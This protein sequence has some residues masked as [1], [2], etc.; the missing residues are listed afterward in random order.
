MQGIYT[1]PIHLW[2]YVPC[3]SLYLPYLVIQDLGYRFTVLCCIV[4]SCHAALLCHEDRI[5][6]YLCGMA[7][8]GNTTYCER[9]GS[10]Y[11][12]LPRRSVLHVPHREDKSISIRV[13]RCDAR[14]MLHTVN[15]VLALIQAVALFLW[16][17]VIKLETKRLWWEKVLKP[18]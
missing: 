13:E 1:I 10:Q 8:W 7:R 18:C 6:F 14:A 15:L 17:P 4:S 11:V 2:C 5:H 16:R 12:V 3:P 9:L